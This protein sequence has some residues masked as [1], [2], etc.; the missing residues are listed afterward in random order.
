MTTKSLL[1][2][3]TLVLAS[4]SMCYAKSYDLIFTTPVKAGSVVLKP[5]QY[6]LKLDGN[7]AVFKSVDTSKTYTSPVKIENADK[8]HDVT[9]VDSV[10]QNGTNQIR[11]IEL[12]GSATNLEFSE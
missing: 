7:T 4:F 12:G 3:G 1:V 9:T 2:A 11:K 6:S 10:D 8:K 5:G